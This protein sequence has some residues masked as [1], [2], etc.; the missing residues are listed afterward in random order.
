MKRLERHDD[1]TASLFVPLSCGFLDDME[2]ND[3][4]PL[5]QLVYIR[6]L[7]HA[8]RAATDGLV[9]LRQI[10]GALYPHVDADDVLGAAGQLCNRGLWEQTD[11]PDR[12]QISAWLKHNVSA[13]ERS[14]ERSA[15]RKGALMTNHKKG[16][17]D[18]KPV[19]DC[20]DCSKAQ[21]THVSPGGSAPSAKRSLQR[22]NSGS[23]SAA[24][25]TETET[26]TETESAALSSSSTVTPRGPAESG[27][28][29]GKGMAE[30]PAVVAHS[31]LRA[32]GFQDATPTPGEQRTIARALKAGATVEQIVDLAYKAVGADPSDLRAYHTKSV[33]NLAT[34]LTERRRD[35]PDPMANIAGDEAFAYLADTQVA[36]EVAKANL[37]AAR[38]ALQAAN[39]KTRTAGEST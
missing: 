16:L 3:C 32:L 9:T 26:E 11:H 38:E 10:T 5:A 2:V 21:S 35:E 18:D 34:G 4:S 15:K 1:P 14:E 36:P 17:H 20:P 28:D 22:G 23:A 30:G 12:Y 6:A 39:R 27:D 29:D 33:S 13:W 8:K 31:A 7:L 24:Q 19:V 25:E 37:S